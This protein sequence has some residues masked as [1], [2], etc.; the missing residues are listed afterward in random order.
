ML[1]NETVNPEEFEEATIYFSD[2][3]GFHVILQSDSPAIVCI[4]ARLSMIV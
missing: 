1:N 4:I 3:V 2:I